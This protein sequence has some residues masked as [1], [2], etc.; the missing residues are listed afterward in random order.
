VTL[1]EPK[2][3]FSSMY[4]G[5]VSSLILPA[6]IEKNFSVREFDGN[7]KIVKDLVSGASF[8]RNSGADR[9]WSEALADCEIAVVGKWQEWKL[10]EQNSLMEAHE[11]GLRDLIEAAN[12]LAM[13]QQR[14]WTS[15][16]STEPAGEA[17]FYE[18]NIEDA[19]KA[20]STQ[21][22]DT[23]LAPALCQH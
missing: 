1:D 11:H 14:A 15:S 2:S 21:A 23:P 16:L 13:P 20:F 10:A 17:F 12:A 4:G 22:L 9:N 3:G 18:S 6:M 7:K 19:M 5:R 8:Y